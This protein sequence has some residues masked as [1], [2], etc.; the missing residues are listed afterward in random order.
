[1]SAERASAIYVGT[2]QHRRHAPHPHAFRYRLFM[3]YLDLDELPT[4]FEGRWLWS[5]NRRNLAEFRR[6]DYLGDPDRPLRSCVLDTV[7]AATGER[8]RGAVRL[9]THLRYFGYCFN[10]V[11]FY[12][13]FEPDGPAQRLH[14]IVAEITNTPWQQRHQYVLPVASAQRQGDALAWSFD[15][16]FH[17][18]PFLPMEREY[19]WRLD[20]PDTAIRIHMDVRGADGKDFDAT[21]SLRRQ[22]LTGANLARCL[23]RFPA[24]TMQVIAAIH[25]QALR[26]WWKRNPVHDHPDKLRKPSP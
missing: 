15:K 2:V 13:C 24:M 17:V 6:S 25:W 1:M 16:R 8:P 19:R 26:I 20:I 12:Y 5:L 3:L 14:S 11:S 4:L 18:S 10:P 9:L 22:P 23:L 7:E 21:L